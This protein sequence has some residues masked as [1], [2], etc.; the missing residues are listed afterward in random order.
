MHLSVGVR[1]GELQGMHPSVGVGEGVTRHASKCG[2]VEGSQNP[3]NPVW[4][5]GKFVTAFVSK[6]GCASESPGM[7]LNIGGAT[8]HRPHLIKF[9]SVFVSAADLCRI[10]MPGEFLG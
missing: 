10:R 3:W 1:N 9:G 4:R 5:L 7:F 6:C 2:C 8:E